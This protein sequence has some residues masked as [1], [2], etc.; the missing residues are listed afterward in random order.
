MKLKKRVIGAVGAA[1]RWIRKGA[2]SLGLTLQITIINA[3]AASA[4]SDGGDFASSN[5]G[6][7][8]KQLFNDVKGW[9]LALCPVGCGAAAIYFL[10]RRSA[11]D[12]QDAKMWEKRAKTAILCGVGGFLVTGLITLLVSY[13]Q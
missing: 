7:G 9:L 10:M 8:T 12:E 4:P 2:L 11:A 5:L 3:S 1:Q 6:I 13:Y